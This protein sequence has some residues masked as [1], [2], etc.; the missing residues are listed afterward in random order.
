MHCVCNRLCT[1]DQV[2]CAKTVRPPPP[3]PPGGLVTTHHVV[4]S[5]SLNSFLSYAYKK[6][7]NQRHLFSRQL[8]KSENT[9]YNRCMQRQTRIQPPVQ[10]WHRLT[11]VNEKT[12]TANCSQCGAVNVT[13]KGRKRGK[14]LFVC[15]KHRRE[16]HT[17]TKRKHRRGLDLTK[18]SECGFVAVDLK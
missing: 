11:D 9:C 10:E 7:I 3:P 15:S 5:F 12:R 4:L 16:L 8:F 2:L 17:G 6:T 18:C 1:C 13:L 14:R